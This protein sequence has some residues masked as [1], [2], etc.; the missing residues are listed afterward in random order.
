MKPK[1]NNHNAISINVHDILQHCE[2]KNKYDRPCLIVSAIPDCDS[3]ISG[4]QL[5]L[6][7]QTKR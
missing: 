5:Q 7:L 2:N 3:V 1:R 4:D 6:Q